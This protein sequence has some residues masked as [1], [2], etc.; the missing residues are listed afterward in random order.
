MT[1]V[2]LPR[3]LDGSMNE[4]CRL[5]PSQLTVTLNLSPPSN[6]SMILPE[7]EPSLAARQYVELYSPEGSVGI[8]RVSSVRTQYGTEQD[9]SLE[10]AIVTLCDD[11]TDAEKTLEGNMTAIM[12]A[13]LK[14]QTVKRWTLGTVEATESGLSLDV[15]RH[16]LLDAL[17]EAVKLVNGYALELDQSVTPWKIHLRKL[18]TTPS[19]E[20]R[21]TRNIENVEITVDD[22]DLCTR[23]YSPALPNG[24]LDADTVDT[25]GVVARTID[26]PDGTDAAKARKHAAAY[27]NERKNPN[28]AVEID[29]QEMARLTG[30][31]M[32]SFTTGDLCRLPMPEW[33]VALDERLISKRYTDLIS[34]P[35]SVRLSLS[36]LERNLARLV[37]QNKR[38]AGGAGRAANKAM[39]YIWEMDGTLTLFD[40]QIELLATE[41]KS[42]SIRLD[43]MQGLI[44]LK[45]DKIDLQGYVTMSQFRA[46][47]AEIDNLLTGGAVISFAKFDAI[48]VDNTHINAIRWHNININGTTYSLLGAPLP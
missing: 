30:E 33:G 7:G 22:Q 20:C 3:L 13:I 15:D 45:A 35:E 25:W 27:M 29:A 24:Y 6:A 28:M 40:Q 34:A 41:Q 1:P 2:R 12:N 4:V 26:I 17:L 38:S 14:Y 36:R 23:V 39:Q 42:A 44:E 19:C 10:H 43:G 18:S 5:N 11:L 37:A 47:R 8:Y 9:V 46:D 31:P 16:D 32:D 48:Q 21:I